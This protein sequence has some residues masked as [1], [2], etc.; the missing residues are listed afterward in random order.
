M[1][2]IWIVLLV[3]V[4]VNVIVANYMKNVAYAKG[5]D[6]NAH[7]FAI[8]FIFGIAGW[9]YVVALPD[10]IARDNQEKIIRLLS[11]GSLSGTKDNADLPDL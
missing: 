4:V 6:D 11:N 2:Y 5:Y 9:L 7:A 8:S 1:D 10:L 3:Y